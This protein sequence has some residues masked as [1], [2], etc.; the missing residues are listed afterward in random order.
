MK[1]LDRT[2][3][4]A[5]RVRDDLAERSKQGVWL[6]PIVVALLLTT[7]GFYHRA[8]RASVLSLVVVLLLAGL[9]AEALAQVRSGRYV[10]LWHRLHV[11]VLLACAAGW[12]LGSGAAL[13]RFGYED[14]DVLLLMLYHAVVTF[15]MVNLLV[16]ER[17]LLLLGLLLLTVP[18]AVGDLAGGA[19]HSLGC[20]FPAAIFF[21]YCVAQGV[22]QNAMYLQQISDHYALSVAAYHDPLTGLPNRLYLEEAIHSSIVM[23]AAERRSVALLFID[24][25]GFKQINDNYSH[26]VGDAFLCEAAARIQSAVRR[27]DLAARIGGDEFTVLLPGCDSAQDAMEVAYRVLTTAREPVLVD[28]FPL[29]YTASIGVSVYPER[30]STAELLVRSA[31]EA[32][33]AA[34][35]SGKDRVCLSQ[36]TGVRHVRFEIVEPNAD[37]LDRVRFCL[38]A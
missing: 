18:L 34:K 17:R 5:K 28:G 37:R 26:R 35:T 10:Q 16:H 15:G 12:G 20:V 27:Q 1:Q 6:H 30:A 23:A 8:P 31:D 25:D 7:T 3:E 19:R 9:R 13:M 29:H 33:Y 36:T 14:R 4:L 32:M 24:L 22:R 21:A 38:T 11:G 2:A